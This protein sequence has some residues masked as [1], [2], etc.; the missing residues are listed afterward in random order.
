MRAALSCEFVKSEYMR[1]N[2]HN[3][4][5]IDNVIDPRPS[6]STRDD[7]LLDCVRRYAPLIQ[8]DIINTIDFMIYI[9]F[10]SDRKCS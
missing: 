3:R 8:G 4:C 10:I 2:I 7:I 9:E 6:F 5:C 1:V